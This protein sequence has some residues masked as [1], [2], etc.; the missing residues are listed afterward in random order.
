M[1]PP[2][3]DPILNMSLTCGALWQTQ[4]QSSRKA[5][6]AQQ[7]QRRTSPARGNKDVRFLFSMTKERVAANKT[8]EF[9]LPFVEQ[10]VR[11]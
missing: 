10:G 5:I 6:A 2:A 4:D 8:Y 11:K 3:S 9:E 7:H 1:L